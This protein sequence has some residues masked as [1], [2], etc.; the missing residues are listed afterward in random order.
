MSVRIITSN[1]NDRTGTVTVEA[2][3]QEEVQSA[4]AKQLALQAGTRGGLSRPGLSGNDSPYPVDANGETSD[5][6]IRGKVRA[7]AFRCDYNLTGM[8]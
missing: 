4:N 5:D 8:L 1:I 2:D 6:L 3:S 7:V